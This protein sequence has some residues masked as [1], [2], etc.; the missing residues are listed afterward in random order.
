MVSE[1]NKIVK[2]ALICKGAL[3]LPSVGTL[4]IVR[5]SAQIVGK[6]V[7]TPEYSVTFSSSE[8]AASLI[9][10]IANVA[11][12]AM[13]DAEDI[14]LRWL[15]KVR[16][17]GRVVIEGVGVICDKSF[18]A[19][20]GI[21]TQLNPN[22]GVITPI[23]HRKRSLGW[24]GIVTLCLIG[25][26][27]GVCSYL[28][29]TGNFSTDSNHD[30][31]PKVSTKSIEAPEDNTTTATNTEINIADIIEEMQVALEN[32]VAADNSIEVATIEE[33]IIP[34]VPIFVGPWYEASDI[35][36]YVIIG[37]YKSRNNANIAVADV[38]AKHG[39][40]IEC[41][42]IERGKMYS[43]AI[44]GNADIVATEDFIKEHKELFPHAWV[45]SVE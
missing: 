3:T 17:D 9:D 29:F 38:V 33:E 27:I 20:D 35:R 15:D 11:N 18:K 40:E 1:V 16:A 28:Y 4:R 2:N 13:E 45:Y 31:K 37:S 42:V 7:S 14:Y 24:M 44:F 22:R 8:D 30:E 5:K 26:G 23:T 34:E 10:T 39:T 25:V 21:L 32:K 6:G 41:Q 43:V 12:I 19:E 36:H